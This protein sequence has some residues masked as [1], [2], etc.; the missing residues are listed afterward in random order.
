VSAPSVSPE[1]IARAWQRLPI[2]KRRA[3]LDSM[4]VEELQRLNED[5]E[6]WQKWPNRANI[7]LRPN[8]IIPDPIT[9][10]YNLFN[11]GRGSGKSLSAARHVAR[12]A[13]RYHGLQVGLIG[14]KLDHVRKE[15]CE[16][17]AGLSKVLPPSMLRKG[18]WEES[19][20]RTTVEL[21]L[22][23]GGR[24]QGFTSEAPDPIRGMNTHLLW[25]DEIAT[26]K[27]AFKGI[28]S[29]DTTFSNADYGCRLPRT[30]G[31][32]SHMV[33]SGTPKPVALVKALMK[34]IDCRWVT[35]RTD[36][37]LENLDEGFR[38][39]LERVRGTSLERQELLGQLLEEVRG[40]LLKRA[41]I[42]LN[43]AAHFVDGKVHWQEGSGLEPR[44]IKLRLLSIDP[45]ASEDEDADETGLVVVGMDYQPEPHGY[46]L[47]DYSGHFSLDGWAMKAA[48]IVNEQELAG[49]VME[50]NLAGQWAKS[51]LTRADKSI[52][53]HKLHVK[54]K[55]HERA[56]PVSQLYERNLIHH[57][58]GHPELEDQWCQWVPMEDPNS[59]DRVDADVNGLTW[60]LVKKG[61]AVSGSSVGAMM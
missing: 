34:S 59:P 17:D 31:V 47:G 25:G 26:W 9:H 38:R 10:R 32:M 16:G 28:D 58:G 30:D 12:Q 6:A 29:E 41:W 60:L 53:V 35:L 11:G 49:I 23:G 46:V 42:D 48:S 21:F 37:N 45:A 15:M 27:D 57:V 14:P 36:E 50:A 18:S 20:N 8:Q 1:D 4:S 7:P 40:A 44:E 55:K 43:R 22:E 52:K 54:G 51:A 24:M 5:L 39:K 3:A 61:G 56:F 33:L 2:E 13:Q 19:F